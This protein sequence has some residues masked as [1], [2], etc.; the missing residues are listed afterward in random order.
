MRTAREIANALDYA[1]LKPTATSRDIIAACDLVKTNGIHSICVAPTWT[2]LAALSGAR[3]SA[4]VGFPHG[5]STPTQKRNEA[6]AAM[7]DGASEL[8]IVINYGRFL[9]GDELVVEKE[10]TAIVDLAEARHVTVKAILEACH[11]TERQLRWACRLGSDCGVDFVKNATGFGPAGA[12]PEVIRIMLD[13]VAGEIKVK[14]SG[15]IKSYGDAAMYLDMGC[16][17]LG[18]GRYEELLS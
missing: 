11:Y 14:A 8:D 1:V 3:V 2:R 10:L 13:A 16:T 18:A 17:R 9:G 5:H 7:E 6:L 4:V 15:G 12:N